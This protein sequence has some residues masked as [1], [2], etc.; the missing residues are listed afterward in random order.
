MTSWACR[1]RYNHAEDSD[2]E[3]EAAAEDSPSFSAVDLS[4]SPA[5]IAQRFPDFPGV[6]AA[7][8]VEVSAG[9]GGYMS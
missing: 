5:E 4:A 6:S 1:E 2:A 3:E 7:I 8:T 9:E